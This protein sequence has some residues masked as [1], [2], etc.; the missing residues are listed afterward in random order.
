MSPEAEGKSEYRVRAKP[1]TSL[2]NLGARLGGTGLRLSRSK[3]RAQHGHIACVRQGQPNRAIG[4]VAK[5]LLV[6]VAVKIA[7]PDDLGSI[8]VVAVEHPYFVDAVIRT[9]AS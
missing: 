8:D 6:Q 5:Q 7:R 3:R 4:I 9:V 2:H 1:A